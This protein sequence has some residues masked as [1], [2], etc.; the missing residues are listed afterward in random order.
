VSYDQILEDLA[1]TTYMVES[2]YVTPVTFPAMYT[3]STVIIRGYHTAVLISA[4]ISSPRS[5]S[6]L[7]CVSSRQMSTLGLDIGADM[8]IAV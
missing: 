3:V 8:K 7:N 6:A 2:R 1:Q 5:T 4:P